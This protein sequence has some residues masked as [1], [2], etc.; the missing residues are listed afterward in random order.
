MNH[1]FT[2]ISD[3]LHSDNYEDTPNPN[4]ISLREFF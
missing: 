1:F 3:Q 2:E 4:S